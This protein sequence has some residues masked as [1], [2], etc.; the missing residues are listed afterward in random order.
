MIQ[1][2]QN[3]NSGRYDISYGKKQSVNK[4]RNSKEICWR[5]NRRRDRRLH[6]KRRV[7]R[8][9]QPVIFTSGARVEIKEHEALQVFSKC[10]NE[11]RT[12][13]QQ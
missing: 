8:M 10:P 9:I 5:G 1:T 2:D 6:T 4:S 7:Y 11:P 12:L 13:W 3:L